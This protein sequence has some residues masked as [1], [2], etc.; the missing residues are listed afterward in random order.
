[1]IFIYYY[2]MFKHSVKVWQNSEFLK[3]KAGGVVKWA[4]KYDRNRCCTHT[5]TLGE[6]F[7]L[8]II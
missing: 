5:S 1:M 6:G 7:A 4:V 8:R 2:T 3:N